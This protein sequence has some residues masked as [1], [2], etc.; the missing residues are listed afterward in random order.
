MLCMPF[1][2]KREEGLRT[3][4]SSFG[5]RAK[6]G[7]RQNRF[8][9]FGNGE[10]GGERRHAQRALKVMPACRGMKKGHR[11]PRVHCC[12]PDSLDTLL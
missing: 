7:A 4:V 10:R 11:P 1:F 6:P 8:C 2:F 5:S 9:W 12:L 3:A